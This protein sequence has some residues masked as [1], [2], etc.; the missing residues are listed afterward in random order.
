MYDVL[1]LVSPVEE[2][3]Q[4]SE[5]DAYLKTGYSNEDIFT[6][7][8]KNETI[9]PKLAQLAVICMGLPASSGA[10][11]RLFSTSGALQR[12]RRASL[13]PDTVE[14]MVMIAEHVR[15]KHK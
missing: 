10:V 2:V 4:Q 13:H 3:G 5:L 12:A 14:Q 9:Y 7:W 15:R 1:D 8:K 6:F 11:E